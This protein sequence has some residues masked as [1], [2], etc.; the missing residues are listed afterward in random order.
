MLSG[1]VGVPTGFDRKTGSFHDKYCGLSQ[2][3]DKYGNLLHFCQFNFLLRDKITENALRSGY[4]IKKK[5]YDPR[6]ILHKELLDMSVIT[7]TKDNYE[8]E[9]VQSSVPVLI[10]FW[11]SWCGPCRML[12]PVIDEIADEVSDKKICKIN[13]DEEPELAQQFGVMSI[14]TL[15]VMKDG[16]VINKSLGVQPKRSVLSMLA[17]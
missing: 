17:V 2:N 7:V 16:E 4:N 8:E 1:N 3:V 10:D 9:V 12:S 15:V 6:T 11:A 14:P 13:V 5:A